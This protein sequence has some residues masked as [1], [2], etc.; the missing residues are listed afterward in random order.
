MASSFFGRL[1]RTRCMGCGQLF[2]HIERPG[3]RTMGIRIS[4]AFC[5][6]ECE[7]KNK[8]GQETVGPG[9]GSSRIAALYLKRAGLK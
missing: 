6:P 2:E 3:C 9:P 8:P 5:S 1:R 7:A 4:P